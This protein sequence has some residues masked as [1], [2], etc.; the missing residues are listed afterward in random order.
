MQDTEIDLVFLMVR[1]RAADESYQFYWTIYTHA[2]H[3]L[4]PT[5]CIRTMNSTDQ[6]YTPR[7]NPESI[8]MTHLMFELMI[9]LQH[10]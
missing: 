5:W 6:E 9:I 2:G 4:V 10:K 1:N 3:I 7:R 8:C